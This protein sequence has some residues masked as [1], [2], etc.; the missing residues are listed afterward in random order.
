M[1]QKLLD[2]KG[3]FSF[4]NINMKRSYFFKEGPQLFLL[5]LFLNINVT[6]P[7][8]QRTNFLFVTIYIY[9]ISF[10]FFKLF[11]KEDSL[12]AFFFTTMKRSFFLDKEWNVEDK[13]KSF[14]TLYISL[15]V[16]FD[17]SNYNPTR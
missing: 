11:S 8:P 5:L 15:C 10:S 14:K 16:M 13:I 4:I 3:C 6:I 1:N 17:L 7:P 2:K 9:F 12:F